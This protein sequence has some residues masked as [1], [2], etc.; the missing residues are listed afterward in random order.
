M[1][2]ND[3][4][5]QF[6]AGLERLVDGHGTRHAVSTAKTGELEFRLE[7]GEWYRGTQIALDDEPIQAARDVARQKPIG[8]PPSDPVLVRAALA[9]WASSRRRAFAHIRLAA[10]R[11]AVLYPRQRRGVPT[12]S[13]YEIRERK[14][15][16]PPWQSCRD[17][18]LELCHAAGRNRHRCALASVAP[19]DRGDRGRRRCTHDAP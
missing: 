14:I 12:Q 3:Y 13:G 4:W 9:R 17:V 7:N 2:P 11:S 18:L 8:L 16:C 10:F 1:N 15:Q 6:F 5:K 19:R